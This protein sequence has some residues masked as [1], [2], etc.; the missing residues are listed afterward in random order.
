MELILKDDSHEA[1]GELEEDTHDTDR[2]IG[3]DS[4]PVG[5]EPAVRH[6][7]NLFLL[8]LRD[9]GIRSLFWLQAVVQ[10]VRYEIISKYSKGS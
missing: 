3:H 6:L 2:Q 4:S 8:S 7:L 1:G 10:R 9:S 5:H